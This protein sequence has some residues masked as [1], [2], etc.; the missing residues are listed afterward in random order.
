MSQSLFIKK[1]TV[2]NNIA[3]KLIRGE[4]PEKELPQRQRKLPCKFKDYGVY[5]AKVPPIIITKKKGRYSVKA[6]MTC[7]ESPPGVSLGVHEALGPSGTQ[8]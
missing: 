6:K 5:P 7:E 1:E 4:L 3:G 8:A 2:F